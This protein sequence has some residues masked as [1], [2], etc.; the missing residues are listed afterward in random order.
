MAQGS[1][2]KGEVA[3]HRRAQD[4]GEVRE[5]SLRQSGIARDVDSIVKKPKYAVFATTMG[6]PDFGD[7][8]RR[9]ARMKP[10]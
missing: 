7:G 8:G 6:C 5:R 2:V 4:R 1:Q 3:L 9:L 10:T